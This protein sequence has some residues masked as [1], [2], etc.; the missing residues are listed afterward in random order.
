MALN[1][2]GTNNKRVLSFFYSTAK[3]IKLFPAMK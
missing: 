1:E 2:S 3:L